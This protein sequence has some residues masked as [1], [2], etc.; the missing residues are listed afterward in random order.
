MICPN[1]GYETISRNLEQNALFHLWM[2]VLSDELG[3]PSLEDVKRDVKRHILGINEVVN[4]LTGELTFE[5]YKTSKMTKRQ[6]ADFMQRIKIWALT[7]M[8][9]VLPYKH[10]PGYEQMEAHYGR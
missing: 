1:C 8:N 5:D 4:R 3:Y 7:D 6:M 9:I 2:Q 10:E